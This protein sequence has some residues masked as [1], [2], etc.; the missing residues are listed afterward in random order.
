MSRFYFGGSSASSGDDSDEDNLPYP[1]PLQ[2]SDFLAPAFSPSAYL[3]SLHNRHQTLEDLRS[4]LRARSQLLNK[5]LLDLVN[6]NYQDFLS[7][8]GS[9]RG[10]DEKVEEVRVG[11]LG[12][13]KEVEAVRKKV[14]EK[15]EEVADLV[16][17]KVD[18]RKQIAVGRALLDVEARLSAL[19]ERLMVESAGKSGPGINGEDAVDIDSEDTSDEEDEEGQSVSIAKLQKH[20]HQYRLIQKISEKIGS[21][22][23]FIVGQEPR[24]V[25]VRNTLLLDLSNAL[26]QA[27]AAGADGVDRVMRIMGVY[28]DMDEAAEAVTVLKSLRG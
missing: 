2:R 4:E 19:E 17:D 9:L 8:G 26:K 5:E 7:L 15:E 25:K 20:V 21:E 10:G 22:H 24:V 14:L 18:I 12:F 23:P 6:S 13:R 27:K 11:L 28:R 3:S 1:T 16:D